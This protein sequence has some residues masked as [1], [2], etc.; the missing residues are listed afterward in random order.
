VLSGE[1]TN[2]NFIVSGFT[3]PGLEPTIYRT[4]GENA[5]H[6]A[7]K[8]HVQVM[9]RKEAATGEFSQTSG[10]RPAIT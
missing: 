6:Y 7:T 8:V 2:T 1:A 5:N 3:C 4:Q 9:Q 10:I